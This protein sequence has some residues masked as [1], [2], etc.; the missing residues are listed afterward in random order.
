VTGRASCYVKFGDITEAEVLLEGGERWEAADRSCTSL[1]VCEIQAGCWLSQG[2]IDSV[3]PPF[4]RVWMEKQAEEFYR[5]ALS[6][7]TLL[8]QKHHP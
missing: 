1:C 8:F 2:N 4:S 5:T 3:L 7:S 6:T